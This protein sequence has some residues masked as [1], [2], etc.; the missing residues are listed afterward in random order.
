MFDGCNWSDYKFHFMISCRSFAIPGLLEAPDPWGYGFDFP[1]NEPAIIG[2]Y[3]QYST[4]VYHGILT[5]CNDMFRFKIKPFADGYYLRADAL[6][7]LH[8]EYAS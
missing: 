8:M 5:S 6:K 2:E 7:F 4:Y 3:I 1:V